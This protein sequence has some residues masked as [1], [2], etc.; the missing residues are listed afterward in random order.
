MEFTV[1]TSAGGFRDFAGE[2]TFDVGENNGVL[3]VWEDGADQVI[4]YGASAWASVQE[5]KL[6]DTPVVAGRRRMVDQTDDQDHESAADDPTDV[7]HELLSADLLET[8]FSGDVAE[9]EPE[10]KALFERGPVFQPKHA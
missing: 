10:P 9:D 4:V 1:F 6:I 2:S 8:A 5:K 3:Y 7:P